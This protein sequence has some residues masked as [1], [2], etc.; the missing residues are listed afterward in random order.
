[1]Q[2]AV[3]KRGSTIQSQGGTEKPSLGNFFRYRLNWTG[4]L[5]SDASLKFFE[6]YDERNKEEEKQQKLFVEGSMTFR[7][8]MQM[9]GL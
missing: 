2:P 9:K 4:K 7:H 6:L 8:Y 5:Q 3:N 1:M